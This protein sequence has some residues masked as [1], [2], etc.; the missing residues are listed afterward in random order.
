MASSY[1][2]PVRNGEFGMT[3]VW[4][5]CHIGFVSSW[6]H[7]L[8]CLP[9]SFGDLMDLVNNISSSQSLDNTGSISSPLLQAM[10]GDKSLHNLIS[11]PK[12]L[13]HK[14]N[15]ERIE[16]IVSSMFASPE[17]QRTAARF[18]SLQGLGSGAVA[19]AGAG[20]DRPGQGHGLTPYFSHGKVYVKTLQ[21]LHC[22]SLEVE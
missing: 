2:L 8:V 6:A 7:S 11:N 17:S 9:H 10:P 22:N 1:G 12:K 14:L 20:A 3:P 13:Q 16:R 4:S 5:T 19:G 21:F 15:L 18:R